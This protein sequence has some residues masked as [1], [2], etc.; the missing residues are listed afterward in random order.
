MNRQQIIENIF[1]NPEIKSL[2][3]SFAKAQNRSDY[4][5]DLLQITAQVLCEL[6]EEALIDLHSR[7][8]LKNYV[9]GIMRNQSVGNKTDFRIISSSCASASI[10]ELYS[11]SDGEIIEFEVADETPEIEL[12]SE[13]KRDLFVSFLQNTISTTTDYKE[14]LYATV[15]LEYI[16]FVPDTGKRTY[17]AFQKATKIHYA[18]V[19]T[20][21]NG[22]IKKFQEQNANK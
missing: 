9:F 6:P 14:H 15:T 7:N 2:A 21:V 11:I 5:Q 22:M 10:E 3:R 4:A 19:C 8:G 18:S 12:S 16:N 20:Y 1:T 17:K 13:E